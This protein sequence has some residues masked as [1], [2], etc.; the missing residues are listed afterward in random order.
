[1]SDAFKRVRPAVFGFLLGSQLT[2]QPAE[3]PQTF[4]NPLNLN[5]RFMDD[6]VDAR[7]A[8]DPVIVLFKGDYYLFASKSG[9]YWTSPDLRNWTLIIPKGLD[10]ESYAPAVV[11]MRDTLFYTASTQVYK[12]ADPKA[13]VWEKGPMNKGYGDPDLF[14]DDDGKLYMCY[15]VSNSDAIRVVRLDPFSFK[16]IGSPVVVVTNQAATHGWERRGDDNLLDEVPWIEGSWMVKHN[17]RYYLEYSA[18]GTEF[19]TYADGVYV[20]DSPMGPYT[21]STYSPVDHK[22]TGFVCGG[23]HGNTFKDKEERWWHIGTMTIS[24][25]AMFERRLA[26]FPVGFTADGDIYTN[27]EFGDFPQYLPGVKDDPATDNFAGM[28]PLSYKKQVLVSSSLNGHGPALASDEDI[29]TYWCASTGQP[30][31][32]LMM[33]L[34]KAYGIR[35]VQVNFAEDG[36]DPAL[37]RGRSNPVYEQYLIETSGDGTV[38]SMLIDK[39]GQTADAPH[40][41]VELSKTVTARYVRLTNV[42]TPGGGRFA[43]RDLRIFGDPAQ[44]VFTPAGGVTVRRNSADGRNAIVRWTPVAGADGY[45]VNY[46]IAPGKLHNNYMVFDADSVAIHSLNHGVEYYFE[47]EAFDGGTDAYVPV[48]EFKSSQSGDWNDVAT[49]SHNDGS[50]W[51]HPASHAPVP[52]DGAVTVMEGHTVTVTGA[53]SAD[54]VTVAYGGT[55][56]IRKGG[57]FTVKNGIGVDLAVDG[58]VRNLGTLTEDGGATLCFENDGLYEHAQD[59]GALPTA[60]WKPR[61]TCLIDSVKEAAPSNGNQNF[62][63]IVWDCPRQSGNLSLLWNGNTIGGDVTVG[64]TG[65]GRWQMCEPAAGATAA[66]TIKGG[67]IQSG[68]Q[69]T[70]NGSDQAGTAVRIDQQGDVAVTGGDFSIC[71]GSQGGTGTTVWNFHGNV[72]L[73]NASTQNSNPAGAAF[74]FAGT[75]AAQ[76][77]TLSGVSY[78]SGGF[79]VEV[80]SG[81]VL[82]MGTSILKGGGAFRLNPGAKLLTGHP[83]GLDSSIA[84]TGSRAFDTAAGY[85][86]NGAAAQVTGGLMPAVI[87]DLAVNNSAGVTLSNSVMVNGTMDMGKGAL[88]L[89]THAF[90]YGPNAALR[91]SGTAAQKTGD[92]EFPSAGGPKNLVIDNAKGVTLHASRKVGVLDLRAKLKLDTYALTVD[93]ILN[94]SSSTFVNTGTGVLTLTSAGAGQLLLPIGTTS[95]TPIWITNSGTPDTV[96]VRVAADNTVAPHGGRIKVNWHLA[97]RT[98]GGGNYTLQ[99]GWAT[100]LEDPTFRSDRQGNARIFDLSDTTEVGTG[101]YTTQ[102]SEQPFTVSRAGIRKLGWFAVGAFKEATGVAA[103]NGTAPEGFLL[104]QNYPNPFNPLTT[105]PFVLDAPGRVCLTVHNTMGQEVDRLADARMPAG[106]HQVVWNAR[107]QPSGVYFCRLTVEGASRIRKM[108]LLK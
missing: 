11:A 50:G 21:Y 68:G 71:R 47:V 26:L 66:V 93:S 98:E 53:D 9:G 14:Y 16:E 36:I 96:D 83:A 65:T 97:E 81:A 46:G 58:T 27:T 89:G 99:F 72:L 7:E 84:C 51:I 67:L 5:Y 8:A 25:K 37:V 100:A 73:N 55:L 95:Y 62:H 102:F 61:S 78:G 86:F 3:N 6:A 94:G 57:A 103:R 105:I 54:Q 79:P 29:R 108:V 17:G 75:G 77:L 90:A 43:V 85:G 52:A 82:D 18:P 106:F 32:W 15:G 91:Y 70:T 23:G 48:G 30:G 45:V 38:W 28:L 107:N 49:W 35:A 88:S 20:A 92:A 39:S 42:Y 44:S 101:P 64:S 34:G 76:T 63:N 12:T 10:I 41:Y 87:R 80:D 1:M 69:F 13:G 4:C 40:D 60:D 2:A 56:V 74:V 59:R 33:D 31:E 24:I 22:P 104:S 19:K